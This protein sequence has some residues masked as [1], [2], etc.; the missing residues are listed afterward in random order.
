MTLAAVKKE[1]GV[2]NPQRITAWENWA[3]TAPL[4]DDPQE[5]IDKNPE[6]YHI[7]FR[8]LLFG[9]LATDDSGGVNVVLR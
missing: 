9:D 7:P 3:A 6:E 8:D 1:Y 4:S 5:Y 2:T